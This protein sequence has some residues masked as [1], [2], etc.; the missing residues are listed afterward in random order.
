MSIKN[1]I[2][3]HPLLIFLEAA[4]NSNLH[5]TILDSNT[6]DTPVLRSKNIDEIIDRLDEILN[7][8]IQVR[9]G[10]YDWISSKY[11]IVAFIYFNK[12]D[13]NFIP[14]IPNPSGM[15]VADNAEDILK[16]LYNDSQ[17]FHNI[18]YYDAEK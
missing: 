10:K 5:V 8:V 2:P 16:K 18:G 1:C 9:V 11:G 14:K 13:R 6:A 15:K 4:I 17:F 12:G 7:A 3:K